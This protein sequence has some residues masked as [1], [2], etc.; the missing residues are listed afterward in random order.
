MNVTYKKQKKVEIYSASYCPYC[1]RAKKLFER[2]KIEFI[3][4][5]V[6]TDQK[7]K[8]AMF[9]RTG[10]ISRTVPQIFID[11]KFIEGGCDGLFAK[12]SSG[13]LDSLIY[14]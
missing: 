7:L 9:K 6:T 8:E 5:D 12:E 14:F 4:H 2:K 11:D 1:Q 3:E 10:E 13:E